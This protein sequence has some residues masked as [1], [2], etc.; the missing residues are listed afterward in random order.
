MTTRKSTPPRHPPGTTLPWLPAL[1]SA[2]A[3]AREMRLTWIGWRGAYELGLRSGALRRRFPPGGAGERLRAAGA[4]AQ[5]L[6]ARWAE[7]PR[8]FFVSPERTRVVGSTVAPDAAAVAVER[9][10][11]VAR[12]RLIY[13]GGAERDV[14]APPDWHRNPLTGYRHDAS[15]HWTTVEDLSPVSGDIKF[16]WE[17]SRFTQAYVLARA[18]ACTGDDRHAEAFWAQA[19]DWIGRNPVALGPNWRCGQEIALRA[20]AWTFALHAFQQSLASTHERVGRLLE[21]LWHHADHV[22]RIHW[23]AVRCVR[24]DHAITEA[25]ALWTLGTALPFL[26]DAEEWRRVGRT[27]LAREVA[28]QVYDDGA[29]SLHSLNYARVVAQCL[30]WALALARAAGEPL[31]PVVHDRARR[32]LR[33]LVAVR[34]AESGAAP[35]Y[36]A[37]DGALLFPLSACDAG[38]FRPALHTLTALL[39]ESAAEGAGPWEEER[40]WFGVDDAPARAAMPVGAAFPEGGY[41]VLRGHHTHA[42][43]RC[44]AYRHRPAQADMLHVDV[45]YHGRNVLV[46]AGTFSYNTEPRWSR[47]FAGTAGHNTVM[48]DGRDQMQKGPRFLW[49]HW[50]RARA[51]RFDAEPGRAY[52]V[53][54][55]DAYSPV[56]H[57][58][59]VRLAG[60]TWVVH[61][62]VR[63]DGASHVFRLQW[64]LGDV[65]LE[66]DA[67]GGRL[68]LAPDAPTLRLAVLAD[69]DAAL[70]WHCG[71]GGDEPAGW[72]SPR[73]GERQPAWALHVSASAPAARFTTLL[74]PADEVE[75]LLADR[76]LIPSITTS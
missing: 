72:R 24:N 31:P 44:G 74:G 5:A 62:E 32:L 50:T 22:R 42:M 54:E 71:R 61:D 25:V 70:R 48:V 55:H 4:T 21:S 20:L 26:P 46:D 8:R 41:Y 64:L 19:D 67:L 14:G 37:N 35:N 13:F 1:R 52:F 29:Y 10:E 68:V 18:Y 9:A 75:R 51:L 63:G 28:W 2:A 53:G 38:D 6:A 11:A 76:S 16:V 30:S 57:R 60:V 17:A 27:S 23:Y 73:Y 33:F 36:G 43:I 66:P 45:W 56:T 15:C 34:D 40:R 59:S 49:L 39:G 3:V 65:A 7:A 47:Y 58:R 12:G 69:G